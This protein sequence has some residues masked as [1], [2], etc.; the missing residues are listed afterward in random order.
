MFEEYQICPYTGLR[1]FTE[2]ESLYFKGREDHIEQ[3]TEQLQ[4]NKFL[5]LTGASGDGKSSLVYAGMVPNARAGFLKSKYSQWS[6]AD[7]RPERAPFK[8]LCRALAKQLDIANVGIVESEL[9]HGFSA[10]V[11][12][13][14]NSK[15]HVDV[16]SITWLEADDVKRA[17][18][19]RSAAN[20]IIIVDQFEEFFT[21]PENYHQGVPSR[22]SNLVL[23]V[24]LETAR[25]ALDEDLPIYIVFT[26]RSDYIGQCAAFRSLPEYIGFSQFFV[27][28]LN[29]SQLQ[30]VIEE[31]AVLSGNRISR[32]LT[33]RLIHDIAE[34]VDQ[35]PIL[36][37]ALNQIW[38]AAD[39]G[40]E[41]MDLI[42]YAMVGGMSSNELPDDQILRFQDWF[43]KLPDKIKQFYLEPNLQNVLDTHANKLYESAAENYRSKTNHTLTDEVAK[44]I[45]KTAFIC[46]TKIDQSRAVRN[47]MTL[48]EITSILGGPELTTKEVGAVLNIFREPGNTFIRPF[49][50]DE[51][52]SNQLIDDDVL[53]IT[54]ESL[55]RNWEYLERCAKEEFD[56]YN[57]SLDFEQQLNRW[58]ESGKSNDFLLSIG[59]LTYFEDWYNKVTPNAHWIARYL[60]EDIDPEVK[61]GK[62]KT[63]LNNSQ[64]FLKKSGRK[65]I[66]TRT[67]MRFGPG[68]IAAVL[69]V[70]GLL[71]F[72]SFT[73][74]EYFKQQNDFVLKEI[75]NKVAQLSDNSDAQIRIRAWLINEGLK[76]G[77][78]TIPDVIRS[79]K[80]PIEQINMSTGV[81]T[82]LVYY[83]RSEPANEI[84]QSLSISDSLLALHEP[85]LAKASEMSALLKE[86]NDL[87]KTLE[88]AYYVN[89]SK[90]IDSLKRK[91]AP[92]S[93]QWVSYILKTQPEN[94]EDID[95]LNVAIEFGLNQHIFTDEEVKE[96]IQRISPFEQ[97]TNDWVNSRYSKDKV[98]EKSFFD[99]GFRFNGLFQELGYLYAADGNADKALQ[100]IDSLL[101][102]NQNYFQNE[103]TTAPDNAS[104][105]AAVFYKYGKLNEL[106]KFVK[107]YCLRKNITVNQFYAYLL[108]RCK[109]YEYASTS[110]EMDPRY[111]FNLNLGLE[112]SSAE[113]VKFFFDKYRS[114]LQLIS[115]PDE[116]NF[117]L[118]LSYKDEAI[119]QIKHL[120][121]QKNASLA[122]K[123]VALFDQAMELYRSVSTSF[124]NT[125]ISVVDV[126]NNDNIMVAR[127]FLFLFPDVRTPF[128]PNE[129]RLFHYFYTSGCFLNYIFDKNLFAE[130]Y[131][132]AEE[133]QYFNRFFRDYGQVEPNRGYQ[134][135]NPIDYET[136]IKLAN[137]LEQVGA[138]DVTNLNLLYLYLAREAGKINEPDKVIYYTDKLTPEKV[139]GLLLN[140]LDLNVLFRLVGESV[141][142]LTLINEDQRAYRIVKMFDNPANRSMLYAYAASSAIRRGI[143]V[144]KAS[145]LIDSAQAELKRIENRDAF[146]SSRFLI[147]FALTLQND[148]K[149]EE[150]YSII[151]NMDA[152][153]IGINRMCQALG[154]QGQLFEAVNNIP[155]N[156]SDADYALFLRFIING[157]TQRSTTKVSSTWNDYD[158]NN[159]LFLNYYINYQNDKN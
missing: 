6:V 29:R 153:W 100:A 156:I 17:A 83:G 97:T 94:F 111:G 140:A 117:Q 112:Y 121:I 108:G 106:D 8:N 113:Q 9:Q 19:K 119:I 64:E 31:P 80:D 65:H 30:Q 134:M 14:K 52:E 3:A 57:I 90:N 155:D 70:I 131:P 32:R 91:H 138:E 16:D 73:T 147:A 159:E 69:A 120:E 24:L 150:A 40:K 110:L 78:V 132:T 23:N 56:N 38:H 2:D 101:K 114:G 133:Q 37:H 116:R 21:N 124:L 104:H 137:G 123:Y 129:L 10:L 15:C 93:G 54:H 158:A 99:N 148:N 20:L 115:N 12:L 76:A 68:R 7:F 144:N 136:L 49:I 92:R 33:E 43:N 149:I 130:L 146:Q 103:Y 42:H 105:I 5:M 98:S 154:Y 151:K 13:Y 142:Y 34:G 36:Q 102:Y 35:L 128:H 48:L 127:K 18:L 96:F 143:L 66:V 62:A 126:Q 53:D 39:Q 61:L 82:S 81:A 51:S 28:R 86:L 72:A 95:N 41:E 50:T 75:G 55:I 25:I 79:I 152:K 11:D 45:I 58:V 139:S 135:A 125:Q 44:L 1:S 46:L 59:P 71:V 118:A 157:Y 47:R 67:V 89:P 26:M 63:I 22:D 145:G 109:L 60:P 88:F 87:S 27:P 85:K 122:S 4:R 141:T 74:V 77:L 84:F 107:G